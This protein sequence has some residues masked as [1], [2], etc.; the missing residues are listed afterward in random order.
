MEFKKIIAGAFY[1]VS[2]NR[3]S[4]AKALAWPFTALIIISTIEYFA[5]E[6]VF[7]YVLGIAS[8]GIHAIFA[9]TTHRIVLLGSDSVPTWGIT[10]WTKRETFFV[11]HI[12]ALALMAIP[13]MLLG[14]VPI[15]G[16]LAALIIICWFAG[17]FCLVFPGIAVDKGVSFKISWELTAQYQLLMFLV[18]IVVP[19]LLAVPAI[20][21][22]FIPY[23]FIITSLLSTFI[24]V[25]EI[26][27]LSMAYLLITTQAYE[28]G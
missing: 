21:I 14:F 11:L 20:I 1:Y 10:S 28:N 3:S 23:T 17:R 24:I 22:S 12:I 19:V 26:A 18:V 5:N 16:G 25:F 2:K 27:A 7:S 4:L 15:L 13:V 6:G 9:I 8:I